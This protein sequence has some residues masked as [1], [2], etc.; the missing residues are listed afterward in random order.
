MIRKF[1]YIIIAIFLGTIAVNA[2][3]NCLDDISIDN[4]S[5][6]KKE[7][8]T[9][10]AMDI[11]FDNLTIKGNRMLIVTPVVQSIKGEKSIEMHPFII[12]GK[13]RNKILSRPY[14]WKGKTEISPDAVAYLVRKNGTKQQIHY[15]GNTPYEDWQRQAALT[16]K[17]EVV[18]CAD[19]LVDNLERNISDKILPDKFIP[20]YKITYIVPDVEPIK[21]RNEKFSAHLNYVV[22]RWDLLPNFENNAQELAKVNEIIKDLKADKDL[23]ISDFTISGYASPEDKKERNLLLS[24]RRAESFANYL[25]KKQGYSKDQFKVEWFG[26]DWPG[27]RKAIVASNLSNKDAILEI[28][29]NITDFDARDTHIIEIDNGQ[30]YNIL[31]RDFYPPL[32]RNDYNISYTSRAFDV[33]EAKEVIKTKPKLLSLNEMFLVAETF[34]ED[35]PEYKEVFEI[36]SKTFPDSEIAGINVAVSKLRENK[37][38]SAILELEKWQNNPVS[39]NLLGI[40]YAQKGDIA[41]AKQ[42]LDKA[43]QNGNSEAKHNMEQLQLYIN[44]NL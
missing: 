29:D 5:I 41:K 4:L 18:G 26:E 1:R 6:S 16:L 40:A 39:M 12:V 8:I 14:R 17:S 24:Q 32:R 43:V 22:G 13:K 35:S 10:I 37:P 42:Y 27:L 38:D 34:A 19:C 21:Q 30:T 2:Q 3:Q 20:D 9:S 7:G 15:K 33:K 31:L 28:I 36:A 25:V 44:D 11:N 23:L